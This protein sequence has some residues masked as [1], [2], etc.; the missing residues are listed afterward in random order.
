MLES[1]CRTVRPMMTENTRNLPIR[2][3]LATLAY[4]TAK[5]LRDAPPEFSGFRPDPES[6]SA[7]E[8][9]AHVCDLVDWALSQARGQETWRNSTPR[10]WADD[11]ERFFATV[12]VL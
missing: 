12:T 1:G 9:L 7:G 3:A 4:R 6:R 8:I 11:S 10:N 2:H 5:V